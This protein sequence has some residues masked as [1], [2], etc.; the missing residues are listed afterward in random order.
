[1]AENNDETPNSHLQLDK[2]HRFRG[3]LVS[4]WRRQS[5]IMKGRF[6]SLIGLV[7]VYQFIVSYILM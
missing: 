7:E 3:Q 1:M 4:S 5:V 2:F 6:I